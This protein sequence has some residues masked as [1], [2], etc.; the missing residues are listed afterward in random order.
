MNSKQLM[1][2]L[3]RILYAVITVWALITVTF[4][5]MRLLPGDPFT[6]GKAIPE[7]AKAALFEKYGL[8]KPLWEQYII[9]FAR[10]FQGDLGSSLRT[11]RAMTDIIAQSFPVS[12]DLGLR[13][14]IFA[15]IIGVL[16]GIIA[17]VKRG[18]AWDT[19]TMFIALVGVSVPSFVIGSLLQYFLGLKLYQA[20]GVQLFAVMG[21][22]DLNS[23]LLPP[24]ALAFG[25]MATISR[26]MRTSMLDVLGQDYIMTAKAKGLSQKAIIWKHAV[27]NALMPVITVM[28]P[29]V[30][31]LLT[32]TFVVENIFTIPGMGKYFVQCVQQNDYPMIAGTT[33]F[34][35]AFLVLANLVVDILYGLID[36]RVKLTGGK[37]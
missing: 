3:K 17:A 35:G 1:Y 5:L 30:A 23:K 21:W 10:I 25:S 13:A 4:F 15:F 31:A 29:L 24:F 12:L 19:L 20:T 32:G 8:N 22:A 27:R 16:L 14:L 26:L 36:P 9:Y 28:G 34:Y 18:T 6:G 33:M 2:I 37:E 7:E 11:G